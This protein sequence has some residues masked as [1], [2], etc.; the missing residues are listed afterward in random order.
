MWRG[1]LSQDFWTIPELSRR[2]RDRT[3]PRECH[4]LA[5]FTFDLGAGHRRSSQTIMINMAVDR[6]AIRSAVPD[7]ISSAPATVLPC[8]PLC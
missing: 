6:L 3:A 5:I 8:V 7:E 1:V 2:V 4:A